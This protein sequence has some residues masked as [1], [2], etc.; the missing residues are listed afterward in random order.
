MRVEKSPRAQRDIDETWLH[1]A[2]KNSVSVADEWLSRI[3]ECFRKLSIYPRSGRAREDLGHELRS[4]PEYPYLI[5]YRV[6]SD[7]VQVVRV[8]HGSRDLKDLI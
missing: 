6:L 3:D 1:I 5:L 7:R 8:V 4:I 2:K